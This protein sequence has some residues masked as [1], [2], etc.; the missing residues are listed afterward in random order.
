MIGA[1]YCIEGNTSVE[2]AALPAACMGAQANCACL[3][4]AGMAACGCMDEASG[5]IRVN[6]CG[7]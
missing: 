5:G 2:C 4:M 6:G 1:Q 3:Q 7:I